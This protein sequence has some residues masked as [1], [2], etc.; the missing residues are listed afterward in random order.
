M[1]RKNGQLINNVFF[2]KQ[3]TA[4]ELYQCDWSSDVCSSDLAF[5]QSGSQAFDFT[6][7]TFIGDGL[8][9][10]D[11]FVE[12]AEG[13]QEVY[14]LDAS[15][16]EAFN[17]AML[18]ATTEELPFQPFTAGGPYP[19][20]EELGITLGEWLEAKG[21]GSYQCDGNK[22]T[23]TATLAGGNGTSAATI[24]V[25]VA[26]VTLTSASFSF[27]TTQTQPVS[28][29]VLDVN[30]LPVTG[31]NINWSSDDAGIASVTPGTGYTATI[32]AVSLGTAIITATVEGASGT[33]T[34]TVSAGTALYPNEPAG[35]TKFAEF[36]FST[37]IPAGNPGAQIA[38]NTGKIMKY[39]GG[40]GA[41]IVNPITDA[42]APQSPSDVLEY[43][44]PAGWTSGGASPA[45]MNWWDDSLQASS[46]NEYTETYESARFKI[47]GRGDGT[48]ENHA[49]GWKLF[50]YWGSGE[51]GGGRTPT[52]F[53]LFTLGDGSTSVV[54]DF[55]LR[56]MGKETQKLGAGIAAR[57]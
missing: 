23:I 56:V 42:T 21:S 6:F 3:K 15:E 57:A 43:T 37:T 16:A 49:V 41:Q 20:G 44:Y 46:G 55:D 12:K 33:T 1:R 29:T 48:F 34:A 53:Y 7:A 54:T 27:S 39:G 32:T 31:R 25:A 26:T 9:E 40:N 38:M 8:V 10:Q 28:A 19:M 45:G 52:S 2:Y 51:I 36:D 11:V 13:S 30:S 50:G 17:N 22:A 24:L 35:Y 47:V 18:Y 14:R 4:Y 5:A